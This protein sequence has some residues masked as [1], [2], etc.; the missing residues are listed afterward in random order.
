[1][2]KV[3]INGAMLEESNAKISVFDHGLLYGDGVFEGIR[4]YYRTIFKLKEHIDR[5]YNSAKAIKMTMPIQ[6]EAFIQEIIK[7]CKENNIESGYIRA[8]IT[9]GIGD[10][11][12][13]PYICKNQSYIIIAKEVDPLLG[14]KSIE[15]GVDVITTSVRRMSN[16]AIPVQAKTMNY[17][18]SVL[19]VAHALDLGKHEAIMFNEQGY[20][21]E[22][23]A[24]NIFIVKDGV[25][26]TP[27][28]HLGVLKGITRDTVIDICKKNGIY[29]EESFLTAYDVN[30]CDE[31]FVTGTLAEIV[32]VKSVDGRPVG[33][34]NTGKIT[35]KIAE[36]FREIVKDHGVK[37]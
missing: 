24:D 19:A 8:I 18:N 3:N 29:I 23:S 32:P 35:K 11:G 12:L 1:M 27:A 30:T 13:N 26:K 33:N 28:L 22:G 31:I 14:K 34:S 15:N 6:Q 20:V 9:R 16:S 4:I 36:Y 5:L 7:T 21:T 37:Y 17:L 10:L 2:N 25:V